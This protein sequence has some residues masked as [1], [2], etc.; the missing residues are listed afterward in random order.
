MNDNHGRVLIKCIALIGISLMGCLL[1]YCM[2]E[3]QKHLRVYDLKLVADISGELVFQEPKLKKLHLIID[4][5]CVNR[6]SSYRYS[7]LTIVNLT[8][9]IDCKDPKSCEYLTE[10]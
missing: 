6:C 2:F 10:D 8:I 3:H 9:T 1:L 7:N 4:S 5:D